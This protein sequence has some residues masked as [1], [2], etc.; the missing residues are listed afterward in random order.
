MKTKCLIPI[1][2]IVAASL[3]LLGVVLTCYDA[4][5]NLRRGSRTESQ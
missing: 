2:Y 5:A 3:M 4:G 1:R